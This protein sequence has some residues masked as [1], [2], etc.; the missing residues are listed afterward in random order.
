MK[1]QLTVAFC[2]NGKGFGGAAISLQTYLKAHSPWIN[3]LI[4]TGRE[5]GDYVCYKDLGAW[6]TVMLSNNFNRTY[7]SIVSKSLASVADNLFNILPAALKFAHLF[8]KYKVDLV[9]LNNDLYSN[10]AA[11]LG[12]Y[13][14]R[15]PIILHMR[16]FCESSYSSRWVAKKLTHLAYISEAI[17][18]NALEFDMSEQ[19]MTWIPE[20]IDVNYFAQGNATQI[21]HSLAIKP[22]SLVITLMGGLVGW[23]GQDVLIAA[24]PSILNRYP[25]AVFLLVGS[26]YGHFNI[27]ESELLGL[28]KELNLKNKVLI[29]G[30]R[31]DIADI[32]AASDV[33]VHAS[34]LP[35]P[36]GRTVIEGMA[37]GKPVI[38]ANEG[39]PLDIITDGIDGLLIA[40]RNPELLAAT[41]CR[42][43]DNP[44]LRKQLG[45]AAIQSVQKF[46]IANHVQ[47]V[48]SAIIKSLGYEKIF[49]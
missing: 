22:D 32:L 39:G 14:V 5:D 15:K 25:N 28:I 47:V 19:H 6:E 43:L 2:E 30:K 9:Y 16:G 29:L 36:F 13:L 44:G 41:I 7:N 17:K 31:N 45:T 23:K 40:P 4:I 21:K 26:A 33:V 46:T 38:A 10:I 35:E 8:L 12:S 20:G 42:L 37:A 27:I 11:V 48:E 18:Q 34:T 1:K 24:A 3:P 49:F